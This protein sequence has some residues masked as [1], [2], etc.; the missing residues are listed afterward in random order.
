[1]QALGWRRE[2]GQSLCLSPQ[3]ASGSSSSSALSLQWGSGSS[4]GPVSPGVL[5]SIPVRW[6]M[7]ACEPLRAGSEASPTEH[8]PE[9]SPAPPKT[10]HSMKPSPSEQEG[11]A[12][13]LQGEQERGLG[14][15]GA[16]SNVGSEGAPGVSGRQ[17]RRGHPS[18]ED[19]WWSEE[20][21]R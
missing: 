17:R 14:S 18:R 16:S 6:G 2:G 19:S 8:D 20:A 10:P 9:S 3:T 11:R 5:L 13:G 1:M 4:R 7:P 12:Q 21:D 15:R